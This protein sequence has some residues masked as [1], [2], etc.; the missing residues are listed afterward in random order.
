MKFLNIFSSFIKIIFIVQF[1]SCEKSIKESEQDNI[2]PQAMILFPIDGIA[3]ND[4]TVILVRAVDNDIVSHVDFYI[5]QEL[6]HTDSSA[7]DNDIFS[8]RWNTVEM[9]QNG[10]SL[11]TLYQEDEYQYL[12][13]IA[14]DQVGNSYAT[15]SIQNK[16]DN[17]DNESPEAFILQPY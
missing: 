6:V 17:I 4:E 13:I 2:P 14:F 12:S 9:I 1:Y 10:D 15:E 7:D 3:V 16:I 11:S 8:Y 5:N